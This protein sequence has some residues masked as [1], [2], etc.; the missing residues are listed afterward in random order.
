MTMPTVS[1]K[2]KPRSTDPPNTSRL[3]TVRNVRPDEITVRL[4][5]W[6]MLRFTTS[7][8]DSRRLSAR[9]SRMRSKTTMVSFIE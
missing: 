7:V 2:E 6:L 5:V 9:F 8:S 4:S 1:A 3:K